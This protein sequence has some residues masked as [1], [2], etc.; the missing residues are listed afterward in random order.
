MRDPDHHHGTPHDAP[1]DATPRRNLFTMTPRP[2]EGAM[3][4][5]FEFLVVGVFGFVFIGIGIIPLADG[6]ALGNQIVSR[7]A[8]SV[9]C[10]LGLVLLFLACRGVWS[11]LRLAV[12]R[13]RERRRAARR[14][15]PGSGAP[16]ERDHKSSE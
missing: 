1:S 3:Q 11:A 12:R 14:S 9:V 15:A 16:A 7:V 6:R 4:L 2:G 13:M 8:G 10:L 5:A